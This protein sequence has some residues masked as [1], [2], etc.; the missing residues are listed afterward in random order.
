M[1]G[2][3]ESQFTGFRQPSERRTSIERRVERYY[4]YRAYSWSSIISQWPGTLHSRDSFDLRD[5]AYP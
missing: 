2:S 1:T 3:R 4:S 5:E